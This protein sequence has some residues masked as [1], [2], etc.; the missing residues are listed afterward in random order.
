M[1]ELKNYVQQFRD[2]DNQLNALNRGIYEKRIE[3]KELEDKMGKALAVFPEVD[4]IKLDDNSY[5]LVKH[6]LTFNKPWGM[7]KRDLKDLLEKNGVSSEVYDNIVNEQTKKLVST[8][9]SFNR[10]VKE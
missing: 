2:V 1:E 4:K 5:I 3:L 9:F 8:S 10:V 6:P 7:S